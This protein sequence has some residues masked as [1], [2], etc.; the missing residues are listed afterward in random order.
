MKRY[1]SQVFPEKQSLDPDNHFLEKL[2][3]EAD[4]A[5]L[6]FD[7]YHHLVDYVIIDVRAKK[8]YDE[9]HIPGAYSY[10][11]G[12][13]PEGTFA[14]NI[15]ILVYCWGPSCNG[16]TKSAARLLSQGYHVKELIGGLEYWVKENCP[17]EGSNAIP[18]W[19]YDFLAE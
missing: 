15:P 4:I 11:N 19:Q 10:P 12:L 17:V 8:Y 3:Y 18:Y 16:S 7:F 14:K 13:F 1:K 6:A 2:F 5:D 9:A